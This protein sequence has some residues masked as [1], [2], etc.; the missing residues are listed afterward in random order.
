VIVIYCQD[1]DTATTAERQMVTALRELPGVL[2]V[3]AV[4]T[5]G[6]RTREVDGIWLRPEGAVVIEVKGTGQAGTLTTPANGPWRV[7]ADLAN[8]ASGPN[9]LLQARTGAQVLRRALGQ[10]GVEVG[11]VPA[12]IAIAG[13]AVDVPVRA[14]GDVVVLHV[15]LLRELPQHLRSGHLNVDTVHAALTALGLD[16]ADT[17]DID[18]LEG[19]GFPAGAIEPPTAAVVEA[20]VEVA[21]AARGTSRDRR[22]QQRLADLEAKTHRDWLREGR[23]RVKFSLS[24]FAVAVVFAVTIHLPLYAAAEGLLVMVGVGAYQLAVRARLSGLRTA[25]PRAVLGWVATLLPFAVWGAFA[26]FA[27]SLSTAP[28]TGRTL[29]LLVAL[30]VCIAQAVPFQSGPS[31]FIEPAPQVQPRLDDKGR[32]TGG[33]MIAHSRPVHTRRRDYQPTP[34]AVVE[35]ADSSDPRADTDRVG[36]GH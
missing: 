29:A 6:R 22:R 30:P 12:V 26:V 3:N 19:E 1:R 5:N 14:V 20:R 36:N 2:L 32:P 10:L 8:F 21:A 17:P 35:A 24:C 33:Y 31:T 16:A 7:G 34:D 13:S 11:F 9:P 27:V 28:S 15:Q 25:G 4:I 18:E 23:A